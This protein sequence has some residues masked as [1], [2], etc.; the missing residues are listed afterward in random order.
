[1]IARCCRR[2]RRAWSGDNRLVILLL[3]A[4]PHPPH[5]IANRVLLDAV[6][7]VPHLTIHSLYD[8]YPDFSIDITAERHALARAQLIIWQHPLYWYTVPALLKYWFETVL[9]RGYAYGD[10]GTALAGKR[11]LWVTTTGAPDEGYSAAGIHQHNFDAFVPVVKQTAQFC[12]MHWL[13]P[14]VVLGAHRLDRGELEQQGA[15]YRQRLLH[16]SAEL[17]PSVASKGD[18]H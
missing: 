2:A 18:G 11:C 16:L 12:H 8:R 6:R 3:Y 13:A 9:T 4:H 7:D 10:G 17:T 1:M 5:S 14:I 15:A